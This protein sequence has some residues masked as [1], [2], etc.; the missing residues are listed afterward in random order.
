MNNYCKLLLLRVLWAHQEPTKAFCPF[1]LLAHLPPALTP[2]LTFFFPSLTSPG[3][4][5]PW[6]GSPSS[7][8]WCLRPRFSHPH[9]AHNS[10]TPGSLCDDGPL[11]LLQEVTLSWL[12]DS[13]SQMSPL[14][15]PH[16]PRSP[17]SSLS[18]PNLPCPLGSP[19]GQTQGPL[20][21]LPKA[22][23]LQP[24]SFCLAF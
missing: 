7:L 21:H 15:P 18:F 24:C 4:L 14:G 5:L 10:F 22:V 1:S 11:R 13:C 2:V 17:L 12:A 16:A 9:S 23:N 20:C 6:T 19:L 8:A 3:S